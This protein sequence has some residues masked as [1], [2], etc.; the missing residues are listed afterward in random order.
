ME[1]ATSTAVDMEFGNNDSMQHFQSMVLRGPVINYGL[2]TVGKL[3]GG[4]EDHY[5]LGGG[6]MVTY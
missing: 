2:G 4:M 6:G 3:G 1:F 5:Y